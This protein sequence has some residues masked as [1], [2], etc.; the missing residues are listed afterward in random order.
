MRC[1]TAFIFI[2]HR[3][4][5]KI[6]ITRRAIATAEEGLT[7]FPE[8]QFLRQNLKVASLDQFYLLSKAGDFESAF[9][10]IQR[11]TDQFPSEKAFEMLAVNLV[12]D[13]AKI[14]PIA[15]TEKHFLNAITKYPNNKKLCELFAYRF[16]K[17]AE[18]LKVQGK[19][20]EG[21]DLLDRARQMDELALHQSM[22]VPKLVSMLNN[23]NCYGL[24]NIAKPELSL[25]EGLI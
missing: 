15:S 22:I 11:M 1:S 5:Y 7:Y 19:A 18:T 9:V 25:S 24:K 23:L 6:R 12:A 20:Q 16:V 8:D 14:S 3:H 4:W 2:G 13:Q 21:I 17:Y 10:L